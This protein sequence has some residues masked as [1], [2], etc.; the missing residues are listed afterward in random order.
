MNTYTAHE[1]QAAAQL[2]AKAAILVS[3]YA[4]PRDAAAARLAVLMSAAEEEARRQGIH[5]PL[6]FSHEPKE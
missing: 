6:V 1:Q 3:S 5:A 4:E 2:Q